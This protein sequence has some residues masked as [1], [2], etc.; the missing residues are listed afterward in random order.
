[1]SLETIKT[2]RRHLI[3]NNKTGLLERNVCFLLNLLQRYQTHLFKIY[4][5]VHKLCLCISLLTLYQSQYRDGNYFWSGYYP[6]S[7][8]RSTWK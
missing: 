8:K 2:K 1:M 3:T 6:I 5:L 7:I 4:L